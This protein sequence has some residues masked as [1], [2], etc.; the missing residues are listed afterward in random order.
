MQLLSA[1]L[2]VTVLLAQAASGLRLQGQ[3]AV[4]RLYFG[5]ATVHGGIVGFHHGNKGDLV[6]ISLEENRITTDFIL[7]FREPEWYIFRSLKGITRS[8]R[9]PAPGPVP[10]TL[11]PMLR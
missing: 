7:Q 5:Y 4:L 11:Y 2:S 8:V 1:L 3:A 10:I 6:N 9:S